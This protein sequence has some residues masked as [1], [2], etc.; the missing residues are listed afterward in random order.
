M[1]IIK[2]GIFAYVFGILIQPEM[3]LHFYYKLI[4][5]L[6]DFL[7]R[8]LGGCN[9]CFAGQCGLWGY[10]FTHLHS[11]D[12]FQHVFTIC[13]TILVVMLLDKIIDYDSGNN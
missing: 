6:P 12:F 3:I 2:L 8:P 11:Y 10:L 7:Y 5:R 4:D 13:G 1:L 9:I